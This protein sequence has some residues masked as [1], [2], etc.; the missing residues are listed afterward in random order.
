M[1]AGV[2]GVRVV[3]AVAAEHSTGLVPILL[4]LAAVLTVLV[5]QKP[6][7]RNATPKT[8]AHQLMAAGVRG[9][10]VVLAVAAEHRPGLAPILHR[11]AAVLAA[12]AVRRRRATRSRALTSAVPGPTAT[13]SAPITAT[14]AV[15]LT[16][17]TATAQALHLPVLAVS[18]AMSLAG[19]TAA[20]AKPHLPR[21]LA[22]QRQ[23]T[24][25]A[26]Q[27]QA[28]GQLLTLR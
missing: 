4:R 11:L 7:R 10:R 23:N 17:A 6:L 16:A 18:L 1:A 5:V 13:S 14:Q 25:A 21:A 22:L 15:H 8:A 19:V 24:L 26:T 27:P 28:R 20:A 3:L 9:V 2:R 12:L